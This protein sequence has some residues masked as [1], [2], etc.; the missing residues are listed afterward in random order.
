MTVDMA[1]GTV[2]GAG[3]GNDTLYSVES[4]RGT[5]FDDTYVAVGWVGLERVRQRACDV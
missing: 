1:A 5:R 4:I 3:V 2:T